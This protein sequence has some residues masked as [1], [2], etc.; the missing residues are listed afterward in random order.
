[1]FARLP[2][3]RLASSRTMASSYQKVM[4]M[5]A[6]N[7]NLLKAEYAVRGAIPA[8]AAVI[9]KDLKENP[10]KYPFK[11]VI[12]ANVGNP[13]ALDQKPITFFRQVLALLDYDDLLRPEHRQDALKLFPA[14]A[15]ERALKY[16]Q[17]GAKTGAYSESQG[18]EFVRE[19]VAEFIS[20]RDGVKASPD[21]IFLSSGASESVQSILFSL[22]SSP[23]VGIMIPIPQYPL[24]T[25]SI[26]MYN[27]QP[28]PYFLD[29]SKLWDLTT[30]ELERSV[31]E[32]R[33]GGVDV[34]ALVVIN[35]GNPT[36]QCLTVDSMKEI[37][38]FCHA[39]RLVLMADEVYQ[40]NVYQ[41][42]RPFVSFRS[43]LAHMPAQRD[44]LELVSFH[45]VSKGI[46]GE[47]GRR[48]GYMELTNIDGAVREQLLKRASISL[49][50]NVQGQVMVALM[51]SP[52]R[53][54]DPSH[55]LYV[56]ETTD[57]F[58]SLARRAERLAQAFN[59]LPGISCNPSMGAMYAF[60][61]ITL[62]AKAVAAA[63][64]AKMAP[65]AFY[66]MELLKATG[67]CVV[68][69]SGFR[70][71]DGTHHF[72]TTFLPPEHVFGSYIALFT[73]FHNNFQAKYQ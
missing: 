7:P 4:R 66:C 29:E 56:K 35:P 68:P 70:Q 24:Y 53:N 55:A 25:A 5:D 15:I 6:L 60:P 28:V 27:G 18:L 26:A 17:A 67:V 41:S 44:E 51:L 11:E 2:L 38:R 72:R 20:A 10:G 36:G 16:K 61:K 49:C 73:D 71:V 39:R 62:S 58:G 63:A 21:D 32:A 19:T 31:S 52:P 69:G 14:D 1:M 45:T 37:I 12:F 50:P 33:V 43:V 34:R 40:T 47:C 42:A 46:V 30:E 3:F 54:G 64:E 13:Q 22:I 23:N 57:I 8:M 65:D 59:S 9:A 48:G